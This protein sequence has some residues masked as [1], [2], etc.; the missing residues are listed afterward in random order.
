VI[1]ALLTMLALAA[2]AAPPPARLLALSP[3]VVGIGADDA[4]LL[5]QALVAQLGRASGVVVI[6]AAELTQLA[7]LGSSKL[8]LGCD[9]DACLAE[10]AGAIDAEYVVFT[11]LG[12]L[13]GRAV[14]HLGLWDQ[15]GG[16]IIRRASGT[17]DSIEALSR[18]LDVL[19]AELL[20][21]L[22]AR[23]VVAASPSTTSPLLLAGV[24]TT[25]AGVGVAALSAV[26][27]AFAKNVIDDGSWSTAFRLQAQQAGPGLVAG[28][29]VGG[30][31][32]VVG[33]GLWIAA[34][35]SE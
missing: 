17:A 9:A 23:G 2:P 25:S 5:H 4:R 14:A 27:I 33:A 12:R 15:R 30:T 29:V 20:S 7:E 13:D 3:K 21:P 32:A 28:V 6:G 8:E 18:Q 19:V 11:E 22:S 31:V 10:L 16:V 35:V 34:V 26:G 1:V 24:I